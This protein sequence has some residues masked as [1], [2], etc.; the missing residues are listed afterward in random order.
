MANLEELE[1]AARE[2]PEDHADALA[3]AYLAEGRAQDAIGLLEDLTPRSTERTVLLAQG[4]FDDFDNAAAAELLKSL[5]TEPKDSLRAQLLL[6]E[7]AYEGGRSSKA[8]V[9]LHRVRAMAPNHRRATELLIALGE[10]L[11]D[12][13]DRSQPMGFSTED[14]ERESLGSALLQIV[15]GLVVFGTAFAL[16]AWQVTRADAA[17]RQLST[18]ADHL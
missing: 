11:S 3:E 9:H 2:T 8:K 5:S 15:I 16:Y 13:E 6:G 17:E 12:P 7:L 4:Y 1:R 10:E 14:P 18:A